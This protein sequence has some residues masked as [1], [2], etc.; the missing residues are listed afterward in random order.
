MTESGYGVGDTSFQ[1]AGGEEGVKKLVND[2]YDVMETLPQAET[3][4]AMHP[5]DLEVSRDKLYRFL[6][7][8]LGGPRLFREKYGPI[9]IPQAHS[10]LHIGEQERDAWLACMT[11]A[12]DQ[13]DYEQPFKDY[14]IKALGVPAERCRNQ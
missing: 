3:I 5:E 2:F 14:L 6:C 11:V 9:S 10:H 1:T 13:Q 7:A 4:R 8:W 12:L